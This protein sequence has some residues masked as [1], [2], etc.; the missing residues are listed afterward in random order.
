VLSGEISRLRKKAV[1]A[2]RYH[3]SGKSGLDEGVMFNSFNAI[4]VPALTL[5]VGSNVMVNDPITG[6]TGAPAKPPGVKL[7]VSVIATAFAGPVPRANTQA[8]VTQP[9]SAFMW[10]PLGATPK[11][12]ASIPLTGHGCQ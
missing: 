10:P 5:V 7:M 11:P 1:V 12:E 2:R 9:Q 6:S 4:V 3:A 8:A